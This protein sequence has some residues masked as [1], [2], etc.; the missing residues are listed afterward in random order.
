MSL[1]LILTLA[2]GVKAQVFP[3][4]FWSDNADVSWYDA[5]Q[6]Q[7]SIAT[8]QAL[9][10][11]SLLVEQGT[12]F[13]GKTLNITADIDLDAHLWTPIGTGTNFPF[14]GT[15]DGGNF[16]ISNLW[17]NLPNDDFVGLFGQVTG[18]TFSNIIIDTSNILALDTAGTL[19]GNLSINSNMDNCH[20]KNISITAT[21]YNIGGLVGG[22]LS[23]SNITKC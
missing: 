22:V 20:V 11:L 3:T 12:T 14:S 18:A 7:F 5:N 23:N 4:T 9:A 16:T 13:D 10:G 1:M 21:S 15:V 8:A 6:D 2:F 19:V 17:I